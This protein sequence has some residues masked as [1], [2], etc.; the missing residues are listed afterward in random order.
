V[1]E[2]EK[3]TSIQNA[4]NIFARSDIHYHGFTSSS[5][6]RSTHPLVLLF[7]AQ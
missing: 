7:I 6:P 5:E 2:K 1:T 4:Q 3:A